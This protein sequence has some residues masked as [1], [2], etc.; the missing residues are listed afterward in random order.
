MLNK[1]K[2]RAALAALY[3]RPDLSCF[4]SLTE[5]L[6]LINSLNLVANFCETS[7]LLKLKILKLEDMIAMEYAKFIFKFNNHM[8]PDSFNC[9]FTKFENVHRYNTKQKQRMNIFNFVFPLNREEKLYI[10]S[11]YKCG[12]MSRRNFAAVHFQRLRN[13]SNSIL[14]LIIIQTN[15][16][17]F[18]FCYSKFDYYRPCVILT[19]FFLHVFM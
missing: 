4:K 11:V 15:K 7:K 1:C 10:I 9:Y 8:L 19:L 12:R 2:L 18:F 17:C 13:I 6:Q 16:S 14:S 5:I 3:A